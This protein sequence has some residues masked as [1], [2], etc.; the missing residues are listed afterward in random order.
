MKNN[1]GYVTSGFWLHIQTSQ[2]TVSPD[3]GQALKIDFTSTMLT[4][5]DSL[6]LKEKLLTD[7]V[8]K[9]YVSVN[10]ERHLTV[11]LLM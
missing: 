7:L 8:S 4:S 11:F 10:V 2:V 9:F 3:Y 1:Q 5:V 6:H